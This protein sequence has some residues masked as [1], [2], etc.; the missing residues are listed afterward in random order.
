MSIFLIYLI[1]SNGTINY[2]KRILNLK[3]TLNKGN[4]HFLV[5]KSHIFFL[6]FIYFLLKDNYFM[7]F[8]CFLSILNMNQP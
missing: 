3:V 2:K 5:K 4:I 1:I 7:V 8:C 6:K